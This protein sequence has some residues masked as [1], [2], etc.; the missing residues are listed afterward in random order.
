ML[1]MRP[2]LRPEFRITGPTLMLT[3]ALSALGAGFAA[4]AFVLAPQFSDEELTEAAAAQRAERFSP[5][6]ID[7]SKKYPE[8]FAYRTPTPNFP[9][10]G[11][12]G[13]ATAAR[14]RALESYASAGASPSISSRESPFEAFA[15]RVD[16]VADRAPAP[17]PPRARFDRHTGVVY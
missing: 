8:P 3:L 7:L 5:R 4:G 17:R 1:S 6:S 12:T 15:E 11:P 2:P 14:S 16:A 9:D 10:N 13:V